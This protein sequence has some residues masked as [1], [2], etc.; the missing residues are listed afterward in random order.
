MK[1]ERKKK[2]PINGASYVYKRNVL[3]QETII[4]KKKY[5]QFLY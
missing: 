2:A 1:F 3:C 4:W 5:P